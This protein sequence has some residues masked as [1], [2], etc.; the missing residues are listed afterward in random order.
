[1]TWDEAACRGK[2]TEWWF[3]EPGGWARAPALGLCRAC[4]IRSECLE[5]AL[6]HHEAGVWGGTSKRERERIRTARRRSREEQH[7]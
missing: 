2:P 4:P 6:E 3:P 1:M 5:W 7:Q